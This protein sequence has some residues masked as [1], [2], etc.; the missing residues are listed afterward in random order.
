MT[1]VKGIEMLPLK[2]SRNDSSLDVRKKG[3]LSPFEKLLKKEDAA[4]KADGPE[5]NLKPAAAE[6]PV[7]P[8]VYSAKKIASLIKTGREEG[9]LGTEARPDFS[10]LSQGGEQIPVMLDLTS[11]VNASRNIS[12]LQLPENQEEV[13]DL[14]S[15]FLQGDV[16]P[17]ELEALAGLEKGNPAE[18]I[19]FPLT[20]KMKELLS[21]REETGEGDEE[22]HS[23]KGILTEDGELLYFEEAS[24]SEKAALLKSERLA[25]GLES[26]RDGKNK[27]QVEINVTDLRTARSGEI[28][29]Q[30]QAAALNHGVVK[31]SDQA[32]SS[33]PVGDLADDLI[34]GPAEKMFS[35]EGGGG[36]LEAPVAKEVSRMFQDY[37]NETG[38]RE[39]VRKIDF[40]LK[41]DNQGE[42]KLILKPEAL[43]NVR[44]N[45]SLNE[46]HIAGKIFVDNSSVRDIFL[47]NMD[48][49]TSILKENGYEDAALE[50][51]IGQDNRNDRGQDSAENGEDTKRR[52]AK[53]LERLE[54]SVPHTAAMDGSDNGQVN[55]II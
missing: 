33:D 28:R 4:E 11:A 23:L 32:D 20:G 6:E 13:M 41:N 42:I 7:R 27:I 3:S 49:L 22:N 38:N 26:G 14:I 35:A 54:E 43:G 24:R 48:Q 51:W 45:L 50:V 19:P 25:D 17:E 55:L 18:E 36:K 16:T 9:I 15:R 10:V 47:N 40:I 31:I 12:E 39:L 37:M 5:R 21:L 52:S 34:A 2:E 29:G 46:N 44:I 1:A 30:E 8:K 53:G